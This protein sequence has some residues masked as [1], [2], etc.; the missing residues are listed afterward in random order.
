MRR[1]PI[2]R[3]TSPRYPRYGEYA[4][5]ALVCATTVGCDEPQI[6]GNMA[7]PN[8]LDMAYA[9]L[10]LNPE[11]IDL[12]VVQEQGPDDQLSTTVLLSSAGTDTLQLYDLWLER[13]EDTS[14][15][16]GPL[17]TVQ[18]D[19]GTSTTLVLR[20]GA[21]RPGVWDNTLLIES[22]DRHDAII[23]VPLYVE[24]VEAE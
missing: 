9:E 6:L 24:V 4:L 14:W 19:A 20:F 16:L 11:E 3:A 23:Q 10:V 2:S 5:C 18:L 13:S 22:N 8:P 21:W 12:G 15:S 1:R 17:D 7:E